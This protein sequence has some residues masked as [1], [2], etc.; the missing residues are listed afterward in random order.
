MFYHSQF[1]ITSSELSCLRCHS[2]LDNAHK[3]PRFDPR[4]AANKALQNIAVPVPKHHI[5]KEGSS[6]KEN[7]PKGRNFN[8]QKK[9]TKFLARDDL[10]RGAR[11]QEEENQAQ[12]RPFPPNPSPDERE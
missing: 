12:R 10:G 7:S 3:E 11:T 2:I 4:D 1:W 5:A 8:Y 9:N 6:H